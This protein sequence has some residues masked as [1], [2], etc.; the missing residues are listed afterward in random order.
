[1]SSQLGARG[2]NL[3]RASAE[4]LTALNHPNIAAIYG[5]EEGGGTKAD[6]MNSPTLTARATQMGMIIGTAGR[7]PVP[8][9]PR[10]SPPRVAVSHRARAR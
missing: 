1:M 9:A 5:L 2:V 3:P 7:L 4:V 6:A 8:A 10:R